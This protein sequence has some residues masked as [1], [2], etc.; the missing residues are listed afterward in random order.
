MKHN[1]RINGEIKEIDCELGSGI[2]DKNGNEIFEGDRVKVN[3]ANAHNK[4]AIVAFH[5]CAFWLMVTDNSREADVGALPVA[6][7]Q[8]EVV[9]H[10]NAPP[11]KDTGRAWSPQLHDAYNLLLDA[12]IARKSPETLCEAALAVVKAAKADNRFDGD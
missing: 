1:I 4:F 10:V 11:F 6:S 8:I 7:H 5:D 2:F 3:T 9:G 12:F